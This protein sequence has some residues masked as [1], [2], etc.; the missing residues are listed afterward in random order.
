MAFIAIEGKHE[1]PQNQKDIKKNN[2]KYSML[3][4][5]KQLFSSS[6]PTIEKWE[7]VLLSFSDVW[8]Y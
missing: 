2:L 3:V 6:V 4:S 7:T 8:N 5:V 1:R